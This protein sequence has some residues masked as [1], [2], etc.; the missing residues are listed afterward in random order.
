MI[1]CDLT[2]AESEYSGDYV[3][4]MSPAEGTMAIILVGGNTAKNAHQL[5][6]I[7]SMHFLEKKCCTVNSTCWDLTCPPAWPICKGTLSARKD[8]AVVCA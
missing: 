6:L 1:T 7:A 2:G 3:Y 4:F 5:V 8:E